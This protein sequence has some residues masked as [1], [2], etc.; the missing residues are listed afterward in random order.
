MSWIDL[1]FLVRQMITTWRIGG[2]AYFVALV[3]AFLHHERFH[4]SNAVD[5]LSRTRRFKRRKAYRGKKCDQFWVAE[6]RG[7]GETTAEVG[8]TSR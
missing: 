1:Y 7:V 6:S 8:V 5:H 3:S 2:R 4:T